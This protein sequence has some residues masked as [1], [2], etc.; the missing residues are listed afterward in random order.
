L[1]CWSTS[2]VLAPVEAS[3]PLLDPLAPLLAPDEAPLD[4]PLEAPLDAP[5]DAPLDAPDEAPDEAPELVAPDPSTPVPDV[6]VPVP[7]PPPSSGE[8]PLWLD[9]QAAAE[10]KSAT[11]NETAARRFIERPPYGV[12]T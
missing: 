2:K 11:E 9:P 1:W 5:E 4:A 12:N 7:S 3:P 10:V 8:D 6:T